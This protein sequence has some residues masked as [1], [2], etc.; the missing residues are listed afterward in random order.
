VKILS[1][2]P[3]TTGRKV[4]TASASAEFDS[5]TG[6]AGGT[7]EWSVPLD[8]ATEVHQ[9]LMELALQGDITGKI[10]QS[11]RTSRI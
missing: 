11:R 2:T 7:G 6:Q 10:S 8:A 5:A 1:V 4:A 3:R 9:G